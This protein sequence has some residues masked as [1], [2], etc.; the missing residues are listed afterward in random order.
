MRGD[1]DTFETS[2]RCLSSRFA[3]L[4]SH[5]EKETV[6]MRRYFQSGLVGAVIAIVASVVG[7]ATEAQAAPLN[8]VCIGAS[9][10]YGRGTGRHSGGVNPDQA[11]PAQLEQML[12]SRGYDAHVV[13][14]G[15]PG[16]TTTGMLSRIDSSVPPGTNAVVLQPGTNDAFKNVPNTLENIRA[17]SQKLRARHIK[18]IVLYGPGSGPN[19]SRFKALDGQHLT[20]EGHTVI[21]KWLAARVVGR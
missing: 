18:L 9:L 5:F 19:V 21:A 10:T 3:L 11:F 15:V 6:L 2:A 14:D 16:D 13:N 8:I 17:I 1:A 4:I 20:A 7:L 12:R